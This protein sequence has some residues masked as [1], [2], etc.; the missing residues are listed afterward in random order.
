[1]ELS[2]AS[3]DNGAEWLCAVTLEE[4]G[5]SAMYT[6]MVPKEYYEKFSK[7]RNVDE[8]VKQS[9]KFLLARESKDKILGRFSLPTIS[10]YFPE[11]EEEISK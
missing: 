10:K 2:V 6:V 7:G 8:L 1:M 4:D 9:M 5:D 11:Y 3:Q